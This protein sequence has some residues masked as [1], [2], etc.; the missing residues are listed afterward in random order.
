M[1]L[2]VFLFDGGVLFDGLVMLILNLFGD[3]F[4]ELL[5]VSVGG[6]IVKLVVV[7]E[8]CVL[9]VEISEEV[10]FEVLI[11]EEFKDGKKCC[12]CCWCRC[13]GGEDEV[14]VDIVEV[15]EM[16]ERDVFEGMLEVELVE[17]VLIVVFDFEF[18]LVFVDFLVEVDVVLVFE[19]E[20]EVEFEIELELVLEFEFV[21][22]VLVCVIMEFVFE[23][24]I[25]L[26]KK[27]CGWWL[28]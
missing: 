26:K 22:D 18:E 7:L 9:E 27:K 4:D 20:V 3:E 13:C 1:D 28:C 14:F 16:G 10:K 15:V 5:D 12:C 19:I 23:I 8:V 6:L 17:D 24:L 25:K 11:D 21:V 2:G